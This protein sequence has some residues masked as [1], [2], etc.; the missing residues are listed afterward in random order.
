MFWNDKDNEYRERE[1]EFKAI[2]VNHQP[3]NHECPTHHANNKAANSFTYLRNITYKV[4]REETT[5][6]SNVQ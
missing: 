1:T 6:N 3:I 4:M 2:L 5:Q